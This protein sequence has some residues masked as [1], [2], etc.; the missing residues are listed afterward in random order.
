MKLVISRRRLIGG[1]LAAAAGGLFGLPRFG[2]AQQPALRIG[3]ANANMTVTYPYI[4]STL[5]LGWFEEEG[6]KV[7]VVNGQNSPQILALLVGGTVD[8]VFCNPEPVVQLVADKNLNLKSVFVVQESQYILTAP[9]DSPVRSIQDLKGKRLGMA[10]PLSG[11]DYLKARLQD[12]GMSVNDV[13][14]V[15]TGFAGQVI[16]AL[17]QK[18]VDAILYW[19]DAIAQFRYA[20]IKLR[21]LPKADWE[22]G[23]Y[24]YIGTTTQDVIE[25][26]SD[27]LQRALRAMA[28]AQML[29]VVSPELTIEAFWKQYPDQAPRPEQ[30]AAAFQQNL[31]RVNQQNTIVGVGTNPTKEQL[32]TFRW[33]ANSLDAWSRM[34]NNLL[35]VGSLSNKVDPARFFDNR[36]IDYANKFDREKL[37]QL[38]ARSKGAQPQK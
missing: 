25:K 28:R 1:T 24:Q 29:T 31:A 26:K 10:S 33:G 23:L 37:F 8:L 21:D 9:E 2:L 18:R 34:Q 17:Q 16:A 11:I 27:A 36:F 7:E 12:A 6:V 20:G 38:A 14:I 15:P 5:A 22:K 32:M 35:R 30:R 19:S 13:E 4:S 3:M